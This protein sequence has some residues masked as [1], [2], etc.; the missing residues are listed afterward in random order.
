MTARPGVTTWYLEMTDPVEAALAAYER[1]GFR[2]YHE[3]TR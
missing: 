2:R 1:R 3:E